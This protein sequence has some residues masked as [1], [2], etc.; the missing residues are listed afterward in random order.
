MTVFSH[1][2]LP[3]RLH[4]LHVLVVPTFCASTAKYAFEKRSICFGSWNIFFLFRNIV[5]GILT[6]C[7]FILPYPDTALVRSPCRALS[8]IHSRQV[9]WIPAAILQCMY[10]R[11]SPSNPVRNT[12]KR[13]KHVDLALAHSSSTLLVLLKLLNQANCK[14][15]GVVFISSLLFYNLCPLFMVMCLIITHQC[16]SPRPPLRT[17]IPHTDPPH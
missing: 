7:V 11:T 13:R 15:G 17:P 16:T 2:E 14:V 1:S 4:C 9:N 5:L 10:S 8:E 3:I 12:D 6:T